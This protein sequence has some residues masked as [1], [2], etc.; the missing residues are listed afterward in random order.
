VKKKPL[1]NVAESVRARLLKIRVSTGEDYNELLVRFCLERFLY[2]LSISPHREEFLLKGALLFTLWGSFPHRRTRDLDLLGFGD[3]RLESVAGVF[4]EIVAQT[5][6]EEDG[7]TFDAATVEAAEIKALDEYVGARV[8]M[9]AHIGSARLTLQ[10][11]VG[12][13]DSVL[14]PPVEQ[15]FPGLLD[16]PPAV[17]RCYAPETAIAEKLEAVVHLGL[18]N[19]RMKDYFDFWV[20]GRQ[21]AFE[22]ARLSHTI[23]STFERRRTP[24]PKE[25]PDGLSEAFWSDPGKQAD[26]RAFWRKSV[27]ERPEVAFEEVVRFAAGFLLP[28]TLAAARDE[29]FEFTWPCG[30]PW[31]K[32]TTQ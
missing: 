11:D 17:L 16:F 9:L 24:L 15:T 8:T 30:G 1:K 14:P 27:V 18:I 26:W 21:F 29:S 32:E 31:S 7:V 23:R 5:V 10:V 19:T 4:R 25:S 2:R 3:P 20:L 22:G 13:G 28:P 6:S 12:Y